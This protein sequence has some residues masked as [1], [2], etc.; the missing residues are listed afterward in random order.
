MLFF[1]EIQTQL[2]ELELEKN[3]EMITEGD[4]NTLNP[5]TAYSMRKKFCTCVNYLFLVLL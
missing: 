2:D 3:C 4:F 5:N 1:E